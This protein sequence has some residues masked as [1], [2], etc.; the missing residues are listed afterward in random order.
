[1]WRDD[2]FRSKIRKFCNTCIHTDVTSTLDYDNFPTSS[3]QALTKVAHEKRNEITLAIFPF[4]NL[5]EGNGLEIFCRSF[6]ID[7]ITELSRFR[8]FRMMADAS[9]TD[10]KANETDYTIKGSF[11][12][13]DDSLKISAQLINNRQ[14]RVAWADKFE[15]TKETLLSIQE[16]LLKE[17][18]ASL[19]QQLNYDLLTGIR[20]KDRINLTAYEHWLYGM[21]ELKK[22]SL[23]ADEKARTY[24]EEAIRIDPEY[25][26]AYSGMSMTYFNEWSCQ[27][28]D[29]WE[30][31]QKGAFAWAQK[32]IELDEQNYVA[33][34]VL[35]RIYLYE[36]EY[37]IAEHYL[38]RALR[39]NPN[40]TDNLVQI[41]SCFV[42]MGYV[43]EAAQLFKRVT[44]LNPLH[45]GSYNNIAALIAFESG[46]YEACLALGAN[47]RSPWIDFP[48]IMAAACYHTGNLEKMDAYWQSFL[49]DFSRKILK[50]GVAT[51]SEAVQWIM[52]VN[53]YKGKTNLLPF[54]EYMSGKKLSL[55]QRVFTRAAETQPNFFLKENDRWQICFEGHV[56]H[57]TEVKGFYDL[58]RLLKNAGKQFHCAELNKGGVI[59]EA[60]PVFDEK[61]KRNYQEKIQELQQEIK[62]SEDN[63]DLERTSLLKKEYDEIVEHLSASLG[64]GKKIRKTNDS[65]DKAR[66]AVTW[67]I[68][69]AIEKI[70]HAHPAL[71]KHLAL[72]VKTGI[73]CTY[74]PEKNQNW[75]AEVP[76]TRPPES[77][78][79]L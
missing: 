71:G 53:P 3:T 57:L 79:T 39:L 34:C 76:E 42:Y 19:Q 43:A 16:D 68:R 36:A 46:Q 20:K 14:N 26:L 21:E 75:L 35:G 17:V 18:V 45:S 73:F 32:A 55:T 54:W 10:A 24:F 38:R 61:A 60:V 13:R 12:Y 59:T 44:Q 58:A 4:E 2:A 41:A 33:A 47:S 6:Q 51:E 56:I 66:S 74:S 15:G 31:C 72:S 40:D 65:M 50:G 63:N 9:L 25:S 78:L 7:L 22:G 28:W 69:T 5:T 77:T 30:V 67:R 11:Q 52:N 37:G 1:M 48:A 62:W 27:L 49:D 70:G 8:Q 23:Q 29:R 64:I